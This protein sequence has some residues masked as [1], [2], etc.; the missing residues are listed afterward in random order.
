[1]ISSTGVI[2]T[3]NVDP[4]FIH[5]G[6][7]WCCPIPGD[8][9]N[10]KIPEFPT[11]KAIDGTKEEGDE[12]YDQSSEAQEMI[13]G[14]HNSGHFTHISIPFSSSS[15]PMKGAY[16]CLSGYSS[17]P[18]HLLFTF[19]S[20][21]G[22]KISKRYDFPEF[23]RLHWYF[24]PVDLSDVDLCE[25]TGKGRQ[26][27][28]R[29]FDIK[30]IVFIDREELFDETIFR[31]S[32]EKLWCETPVVKPEFVKKG[33]YKSKPRDSIPIPI[34]RDDPK[35]VDPLFLMVKCK[36]DAYG[37]D[38]EHY[39]QSSNA[40]RMLKGE[41]DVALS[42]LSIPFPSPCPMKGAYICV[43]KDLGS[44]SLLFT[45]TDCD[46]K[47]T[48]KKYEFA[49]SEHEYEC[50]FLPIDLANVVLCEVE[51]KGMWYYENSRFFFIYSLVFT[52]S[53]EIIRS[54]RLSSLPWK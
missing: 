7:S 50:L 46:G 12:K 27:E 21:K 36:N 54:E 47:K 28:K 51:G 39:D 43:D 33:D 32:K 11:I 17:P 8:A 37:N 19:T 9:P 5:K 14:E 26:K 49:R 13:K 40:Q 20:S 1:M 41:G 16:I 30:S 44:P 38:S 24:L 22:E 42:H 53:E 45:F 15:S 35:L 23:Y 18:S 34:P 6:S 2:Q 29:Y 52:L 10:I 48:F 3:I 31:E 4:V 25:I